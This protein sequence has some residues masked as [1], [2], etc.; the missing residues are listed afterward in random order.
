MVDYKRNHYVPQWYQRRFLSSGQSEQKFAYLD[1]SPQRVTRDGRTHTRRGL[2]HWGPRR[3]FVEE[4]L[5]TT[6]FGNWES[7]EIE[8]K[9]F[10]QIDRNGKAAV[11]YFSSFEHP[12]AD[13]DALRA[14]LLFM[15]AQKMRTP[16]GL[17]YLSSI[18]GSG[19]RNS[20]LLAMQ[21][22]YRMYCAI[23]TECVWLLADANNSQT[24]FLVTDHPVA[25]YN[26]AVFPHSPEFRK[27]G[28]PPVWLNGTHTLFPLDR[29]RI[30]ILTNLSWVRNPYG[31]PKATRPNPQLFRNAMFK[32][33]DIQT[34]RA[35]SETE[36]I[37][38]N[39]MLKKRAR[40]FVAA[41]NREWLYPED[42]VGNERWDKI[43][44]PYLLM[45]DPRSVNFSTGVFMGGND[46]Q[47]AAFD[48]YGRRP[49]QPGYDPEASKDQEWN[50]FHAF[51]GEFARLYGPARRGRA[52][53]FGKLDNAEDSP[54]YH[55]YHLRLEAHCK[56]RLKRNGKRRKK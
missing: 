19:D 20:L 38:I 40:R 49:G 55:A 9:F 18:I 34:H 14:L 22:L 31:N 26:R 13:G 17:D 48:E 24:K 51:Q 12:S 30:L 47:V 42:I 27:E 15:A 1:M 52:F 23:W 6:R 53:N 32:F 35:L 28:D 39:Y 11:E 43:A 44:E 33:T 16:K 36:V 25:V 29:E 46:G 45:P 8:E 4:D 50:A 2:L 7:T 10:G 56:G 54:D 37:R 41:A 3:C 5:Y 21:E